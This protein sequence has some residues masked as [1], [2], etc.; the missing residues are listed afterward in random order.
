MIYAI[1]SSEK[2]TFNNNNY[3]LR[4][5]TKNAENPVVLFLHGGCGA[6]DRAFIIKWQS[7]LADVATLVAWDQRGAGIAYNR[8]IAKTEVLTKD[9]YLADLDN[10]INYLK[11]RFN[12]DK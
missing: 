2:I 6:A 9:L 5:R 1:D 10:V 12:K 11:Q 8:K 4:I 7:D 3:Y